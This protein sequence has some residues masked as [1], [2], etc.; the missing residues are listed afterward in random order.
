M[1]YYVEELGVRLCKFITQSHVEKVYTPNPTPEQARKV[2]A[3]FLGHILER[4]HEG[5]LV[6]YTLSNGETFSKPFESKRAFVRHIKTL[7][8]SLA[9]DSDDEAIG[10]YAKQYAKV[11]IRG[12]REEMTF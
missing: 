5:V 7:Y 10:W 2:G 12:G 3:L 4:K 1:E 6:A 11:E 9:D 8:P